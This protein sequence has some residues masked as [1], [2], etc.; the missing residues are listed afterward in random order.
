MGRWLRGRRLPRREALAARR[1]AGEEHVRPK[2]AFNGSQHLKAPR[3]G[4]SRL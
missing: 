3:G 1:A 2:G 4:A